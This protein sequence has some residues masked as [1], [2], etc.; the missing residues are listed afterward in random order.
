MLNAIQGK[1][2]FGGAEESIFSSTDVEK[3][4]VG[5]RQTKASL[6]DGGKNH[7]NKSM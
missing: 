4:N 5:H 1:S 7:L 6:K 2:I 3:A